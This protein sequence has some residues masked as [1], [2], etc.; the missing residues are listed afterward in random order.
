MDR[1]AISEFL[2]RS[3]RVTKHSSQLDEA[4][5][6]TK[7][8]EPFLQDILGWDRYE[9]MVK[10]YSVQMGTTIKKV[11]Y[12][13]ILEDTPVIFIEVKGWDEHLS[14]GDKG[15]LKSYMRQQAVDWGLLT[16][17]KKYEILKREKDPSKPKEISIGT[18][19]LDDLP[20]KLDLLE[21]LS[22]DS[23]KSGKSREI[24]QKIQR[25]RKALKKIEQNQ[26]E[27]VN[28]VTKLLTEEVGD[29]VTQEIEESSN[30]FI[31]DMITKLRY[32]YSDEVEKGDETIES[33]QVQQDKFTPEEKSEGPTSQYE[34]RIPILKVIKQMGGKGKVRDIL[35]KVKKIMEPK[36]TEED[37][38]KVSGN[39]ERWRNHARWQRQVMV[40]DGL[41]D[42]SSPRGVWAITEKGKRYLEENE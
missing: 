34:Y 6:E 31:N 4:N 13:I 24:G 36:L 18:I 21:V 5:T 11:D 9:N 29:S 23:I 26:E 35:P 41:L 37:F 20:N 22:K 2:E 25:R 32:P 3:K 39:E 19:Q 28:K 40:D 8:V 16:N 38:E 1:G 12:A 7:I 27:L 10:Q 30:K 14:E 33:V 17:G 15:Q 42:D